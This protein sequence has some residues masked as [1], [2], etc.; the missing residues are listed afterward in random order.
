MIERTFVPD[1]KK[2]FFMIDKVLPLTAKKTQDWFFENLFFFWA[3]NGQ[4]G[5]SPD[6]N[7]IKNIQATLQESV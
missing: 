5:N 3:Y 6:L 2:L 1:A 7:L 4:S